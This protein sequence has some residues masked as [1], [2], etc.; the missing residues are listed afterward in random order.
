MASE[1]GPSTGTPRHSLDQAFAPHL[2][3]HL[4]GAWSTGS[5]RESAHISARTS[6]DGPSRTSSTRR[7]SDRPRSAQSRPRVSFAED[8]EPP[9]EPP[10]GENEWEWMYD[11]D[12]Q[13]FFMFLNE[14]GAPKSLD[15]GSEGHTASLTRWH[16]LLCMSSPHPNCG[17]I[18]VMG[19]F[20]RSAEAVVSRVE[21]RDQT[22]GKGTFGIQFMPDSEGKFFLG[23]DVARGLINHRWPHIQ[24]EFLS[25][26]TMRT[27]Y[28]EQC[29]FVNDGTVYQVTRITPDRFMSEESKAVV[30]DTKTRTCKFRI[31]GLV[32]FGC[33]CGARKNP[34]LSSNLQLHH[35]KLQ[36]HDDSKVLTCNATIDGQYCELGKPIHCSLHMELF[37]N[38]EKR[39]IE[40]QKK[41]ELLGTNADLSER[42]E[43][44][45]SSIHT[46]T[47]VPDKESI[48]VLAITL[49]NGITP[50]KIHNSMPTSSSV[51]AILGV[52]NDTQ[53]GIYNQSGNLWFLNRQESDFFDKDD[54]HAIARTSEYLLSVSARYFEPFDMSDANSLAVLGAAQ[55]PRKHSTASSQ[56]S[57]SQQDKA[58][59]EIDP[60]S[61]A[62]PERVPENDDE[63]NGERTEKLTWCPH[64]KWLPSAIFVENNLFAPFIDLESI[65]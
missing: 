32:S 28:Y 52:E 31:G 24:Y 55:E 23:D 14:D 7:A 35:P 19:R 48:I 15:C 20:P 2:G 65:L 37:V 43:T 56:A 21:R 30:G 50:P 27:G 10:E 45:L 53:K 62:L 33:L 64:G 60:A 18:Y 26:A 11:V 38:G 46:V 9:T 17:M 16:E 40:L 36:L 25:K 44:D 5:P 61:I 39:P 8:A 41:N 42:H 54:L 13:D 4:R 47:L 22:G 3:R 6:Q 49:E 1:P 51:K 59:P 63:V 57:I 29:T 58:Q 34:R 12:Y